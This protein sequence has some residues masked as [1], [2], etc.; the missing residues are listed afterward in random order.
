VT[1]TQHNAVNDK[2]TGDTY[3]PL[4]LK[5]GAYVTAKVGSHHDTLPFSD[6]KLHLN[7]E[8]RLEPLPSLHFVPYYFRANRGGKGH[9]RVGLRRW[10]R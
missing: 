4:E 5:D 8:D 9:M 10:L 3:V 7:G 1:V 2:A 6:A